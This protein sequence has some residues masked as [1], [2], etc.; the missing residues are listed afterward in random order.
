MVSSSRSTTARRRRVDAG[1]FLTGALIL[2]G[3]IAS[4]FLIFSDNVQF[5]RVGLVAALW[6][7]VVAA[8]AATRYRKEAA[9]D[10]AKVR[11]IQTVYELQLEREINARREYEMGVEAR[12]RAE[13]GADA[14]EIA[15]LRA[16]LTVLRESLQR[17]FDGA[18]PEER[19][20]LGST[21]VEALPGGN[22]DAF[23]DHEA[24]FFDN[25]AD[26]GPLPAGHGQLSPSSLKPVFEPGH[27]ESA[28]FADPYDDPVTAE[29]SAVVLDDFI[30]AHAAVPSNQPSFPDPFVP[31]A[32]QA[33][34]PPYE[35][36]AAQ[37][38]HPGSQPAAAEAG[39]G[40]PKSKA[41]PPPRLVAPVAPAQAP[42]AEPAAT[43]ASEITGDL[44]I[45]TSSRRRRREAEGEQRLSVADIMAN[46]RSETTGS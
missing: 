11:D 20:A 21:T 38:G 7:A 43:P 36:Y 17:L 44:P 27:P 14:T 23:A 42:A 3:V 22:F 18:M 5:V 13:V 40:K 6:A 41:S 30:R 16:E 29:T 32:T 39:P 9:V 37:Q 26:A 34:E 2:L 35:P 25:P 12:V 15:A 28:T 8:F 4:T 1:K 24:D 33:P 31:E 10:S 45:G 19:V 46:L